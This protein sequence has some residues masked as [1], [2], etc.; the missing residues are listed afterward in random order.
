MDHRAED[1]AGGDSLIVV[2]HDDQPVM[3]RADWLQLLEADGPTEVDAE[4][5]EIVRELRERC[6]GADAGRP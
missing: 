2:I 1:T 3:T 4:A 6:E 5:A